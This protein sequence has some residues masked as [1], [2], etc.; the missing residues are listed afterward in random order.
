MREKGAG[1]LRGDAGEKNVDKWKSRTEWGKGARIS[2]MGS[3][4]GGEK[5]RGMFRCQESQCKGE[6]ANQR[7]RAG[8]K[9]FLGVAFVAP[10]AWITSIGYWILENFWSTFYPFCSPLVHCAS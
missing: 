10:R 4:S 8:I 1:W 2:G 7:K 3:V 6:K 5:A 9:N